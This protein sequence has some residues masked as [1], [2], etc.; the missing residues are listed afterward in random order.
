M[1]LVRIKPQLRNFDFE[2]VID[3]VFN[4]ITNDVELNGSDFPKVDFFEDEKAV[5][6]TAELPGMSKDE[7]KLVLEDGVLTLSGEMK[8]ELDKDNDKNCLYSERFF[9]QFERKFRLSDEI[10]TGSVKA[11]F[12]NGL[13]KVQ[14]DKAKPGEP[15]ERIIKVK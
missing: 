4:G 9:G 10:D 5:Y 13:L 11:K 2:N 15:K 6:L 8:N 3:R 7:I 1:T 12:E 14:I